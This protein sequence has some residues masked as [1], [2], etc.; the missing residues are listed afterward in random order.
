MKHTI[1]LFITFVTLVT[2]K[3]SFSQTIE[4]PTKVSHA[5]PLFYDFVRDL[6]A[7]RGEK[8]WNVGLELKNKKK[9]NEYVVLAEYEFVPMDRLG[10]EVE[11]DLSLFRGDPKE[12]PSNRLEALRLSTQYT[13]YVSAEKRISIAVGYTQLLGFESFKE[14]LNKP[15]IA[16]TTFSPFFIIAKSLNSKIH[17]LLYTYPL[18][19][20]AFHQSTLKTTW[21]SNASFFYTVK[22]KHMIGLETAHVWNTHYQ[23]TLL[24][25]LKLKL[26]DHIHLGIVATYSIQS[27][28][29]NISSFIRLIYEPS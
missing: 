13:S 20:Y 3:T 19:E 29:D 16:T 1:T 2:F 26:K 7:H 15:T 10:L 24:P 27:A 22:E 23:T 11:M 9:Y 4:K 28:N 18:I 6:G 5:E 14:M 12:T 8:E 21:Q 17:T 25:Q